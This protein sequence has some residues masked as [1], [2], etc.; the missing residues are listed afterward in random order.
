M[1]LQTPRTCEF[2]E[3]AHSL[4]ESVPQWFPTYLDYLNA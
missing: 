4:R 3:L 1:L 2:D